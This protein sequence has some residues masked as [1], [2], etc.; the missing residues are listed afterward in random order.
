MLTYYIA[1][2][3]IPSAMSIQTR[4]KSDTSGIRAEKTP[5]K[6][7]D[8]SGINTA[9]AAELEISLPA[10]ILI[11]VGLIALIVGGIYWFKRADTNTDNGVSP[12]PNVLSES[13]V[14]A[15]ITLDNALVKGNSDAQYVFAEYSDFECP[16]C[17]MFATGWDPQTNSYNKNNATYDR[18]NET[19]VKT[20]KMRYAYVPYI[21][22]EA[23]KPAA[24]NEVLG[25]HCAVAQN[26]GFEYT[27]A[28][29]GK[30]FANG[31]GID[32]KGAQ[33]ES[34]I[35]IASELSLDVDAFTQ[36]YDK[37]DIV[38]IDKNQQKVETEVRSPWV[39]KYG[40]KNFGTPFFVLCKVSSED[41]NKCVG[42]VFVG[43]WPFE[44]M[45]KEVDKFMG[46]TNPQSTN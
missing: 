1:G 37:R 31:A 19:Y 24:T 16:Y 28:V 11:V 23:H 17:K 12:L 27:E 34:I 20:G 4:V 14:P 13:L 44:D 43:A 22:V 6:S 38:S 33:K 36:C 18:L 9:Q 46:T 21:G 2:Y 32:K 3:I 7:L 5:L 41:S 40:L 26:K 42:N 35:A 10:L 39:A 29:F 8:N 15:T 45:K 25:Y 30:T